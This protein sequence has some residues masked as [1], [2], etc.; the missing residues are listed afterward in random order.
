MRRERE[1]TVKGSWVLVAAITATVLVVRTG[2]N[3][4]L[5]D[6]EYPKR[7]LIQLADGEYPKR[8]LIQVADGEYP[9]RPLIQ[10]AD[11]EYPKRPLNA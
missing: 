9:K 10:L 11:G 1:P 3:V 8:P 5:A 2:S 4:Q 6:G 7:P